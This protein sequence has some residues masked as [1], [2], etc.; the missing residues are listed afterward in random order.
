MRVMVIIKADKR[1]EAGV[2]P[3]DK[4]LAEMGKFNDELVRAGVMLAGDGLHPSSRAV[5]V[6]FP[7]K[8]VIDGPF[9]EAKELVAGYWIWQ[10]K[11]LEEAIEWIKRAPCDAFAETEVELRPIFE[12]SD[13]EMSNETRQRFE[14]QQAQLAAQRK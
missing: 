10:V 7:D 13:F 12:L 6:R 9:A 5:R 11:S 2:L 4:E 14:A 3:T 8:K 1:S